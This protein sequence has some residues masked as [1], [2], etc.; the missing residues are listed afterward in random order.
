MA[1][2]RSPSPSGAGARERSNSIRHRFP[3][4]EVTVL[5]GVPITTV[6]RTLLDLATVLSA[7]RLLSAINQAEQAQ[8]TDVLSLPALLDRHRG[9][10]EAARL[11]DVLASVGYGV[12]VEELEARFAEFLANR[13]LPRPELNASI[14]V[15]DRFYRPDCLWRRERLIVRAPQRP[16]PRDGAG[17]Q[18]RRHP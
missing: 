3:P 1:G 18:P 8:R 17:D 15:G 13:R 4:D 6:P 12:T 9:K 2:S 16:P 10:R 11:R 5:D 7:E 14:Q